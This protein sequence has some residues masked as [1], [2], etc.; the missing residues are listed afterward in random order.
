MSPSAKTLAPLCPPTLIRHDRES[1]TNREGHRRETGNISGDLL[2]GK[3]NHPRLVA[4]VRNGGLSNVRASVNQY[5]EVK[6]SDGQL[7]ATIHGLS[8]EPGTVSGHRVFQERQVKGMTVFS[9]HQE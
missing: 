5:H 9:N 8:H 7:Q 2:Q 4:E 6:V 3:G 1:R